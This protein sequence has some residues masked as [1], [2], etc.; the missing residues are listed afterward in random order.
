MVSVHKIKIKQDKKNSLIELFQNLG[1]NEED[2]S[3]CFKVIRVL[4]HQSSP[5]RW[6]LE[7][8]GQRSS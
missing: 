1:K 3:Y 6:L 2:Y 4:K 5:F 7:S 8:T